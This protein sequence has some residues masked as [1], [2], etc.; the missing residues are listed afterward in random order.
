MR[1]QRIRFFINGI[2][3]T[4][5]ALAVRSVSMM[6]NSYVTRTVGAEGVGLFTL[7]MTVYG[8]AI[9]FA[10]SGIS[11]TVTRLVAEDIG[12]RAGRGIRRIMKNAT[13]YSLLFSITASVLL[14]ILAPYL[15]VAVLS[16]TRTVIPLRLL[17]LSL[18][19]ISLCAA[20]GGYFVGVR[21]I[22]HNAVLGVAAQAVK[23]SVTLSLVYRFVSYGTEY[24]VIALALSTTLTE[25]LI[26][27][28]SL[29]QYL[30]DRGRHRV[31]GAQ[32]A[33]P[34]S[35]VT[36][37]AL[38][39]AFSA[40]I[41]SALL[42]LEH[43]LI[44]N[45]LRYSGSTLSESLAAYGILHG[46]AL[47]VL[48]LPMTPLSS[49]S[50]LLV[51]EFA[52]SSARGERERLSRITSEALNTTLVYAI[53]TAVL[54]YTFAEEIGY[55]MYDSY[56]AGHYIAILAPVI[57]IMYLD[58]VADAMLKG[59]GEQV[60]SMWVNIADSVLSVVLVW[61]LI[62][63]MGI[64]GYAAV[65]VVMELFNFTLSAARLCRRIRFR[66]DLSHSFLLPLLSALVASFISGRVFV[67]V[68][69]GAP[70][71]W[72]LLKLL[73]TVCIFYAIYKSVSA[74]FY[75]RRPLPLGRA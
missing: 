6:F 33:S 21:R 28:I 31:S 64:S 63:I 75:K 32:H 12:E 55:A 1:E 16:D 50:G 14:L 61:C 18:V 53:A 57:P 48:I 4:V 37:M 73:F 19:P 41:R 65:I 52:S 15:G 69:V 29:F 22:T 30:F 43:V 72:L 54:M 23:I 3:L 45:R 2:M 5:T 10:T 7:I 35:D 68:S 67:S 34:F 25:L 60:Y 13:L 38:P 56:G 40:Y 27:L 26:F 71:G 47:P 62:P 36:A 42:T 59:I 8:F 11:L 49:F 44:P 24:A 66:I 39:L 9:T 74:V 58:H 20:F 51:P 46:M 70:V 17:A